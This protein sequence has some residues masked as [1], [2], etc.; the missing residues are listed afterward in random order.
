[1]SNDVNVGSFVGNSSN[2]GNPSGGVPGINSN[3][4][5]WG[6]YSNAGFMISA[7]RTF[8]SISNAGDSISFLVIRD[9]LFKAN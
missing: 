7:N 5:A 8:S 2:N 9:F 1:M 6:L 4:V 3:G